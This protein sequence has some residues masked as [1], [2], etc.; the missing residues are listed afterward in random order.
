MKRPNQSIAFAFAKLSTLPS[1]CVAPLMP[2]IL[3]GCLTLAT[4]GAEPFAP[5]NQAQAEPIPGNFLISQA[6]ADRLPP[7]PQPVDIVQKLPSGSFSPREFDFQVPQP[8]PTSP[9]FES[10]L[11]YVNQSSSLQLQ[12]VQQLE[13]TAFVRQYNGRSV[14]Q[15][16]VFNQKSNAQQQAKELKSRGIEARIV[17]LTNGQ[18]M[19]VVK[20]KSYFV[21]IPASRKDLPL[22]EDQ[23]RR[24]RIDVPV[25]VSQRK[26]PRGLHVRVGPFSQRGQAERW[27]RYLV[28]SGL[29]NA[30]VYY[31]R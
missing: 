27:N 5:Q 13:P 22:I 23:V 7:P 20:S 26:E 25:S 11:V 19:G 30:R 2:L 1:S 29:R 16:G 6:V 21:V 28:D 10:Y 18:E 24:L 12:E 17:S 3:G 15:A 14:I 8:N 4:G 9:N 31:G